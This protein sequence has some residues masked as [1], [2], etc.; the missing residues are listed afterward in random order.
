MVLIDSNCLKMESTRTTPVTLQSNMNASNRTAQ[1]DEIPITIFFHNG[2]LGIF[3]K[4][5][6]LGRSSI[7]PGKH[8]R[9]LFSHVP[10]RVDDDDS[11]K[12][13]CGH[14]PRIVV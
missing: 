6:D 10:C 8:S 12:N 7:I 1:T 14:L 9:F 4:Q 5:S 3:V 2:K 11:L 13:P